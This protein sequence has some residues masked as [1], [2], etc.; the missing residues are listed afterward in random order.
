[1]SFSAIERKPAVPAP[2]LG[3]HTN[4]ILGDLLGLSDGEIG[5]LHDQG[6]VAGSDK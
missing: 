2:R 4:E 6:V 3:Q 1:M 5:K